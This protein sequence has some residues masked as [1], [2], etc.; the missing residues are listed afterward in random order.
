VAGR[1]AVDPGGNLPTLLQIK[2]RRLKVECGQY[3]AGTSA[4]PRFLLSHGEDP[5]TK[6]VAPQ[7][8]RKKKPLNRQEAEVRAAQ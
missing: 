8:L 2:T 4:L 1:L 6:S 3:R 5:A 7:V